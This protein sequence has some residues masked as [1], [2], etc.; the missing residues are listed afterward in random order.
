MDTPA[1]PAPKKVHANFGFFPQRSFYMNSFPE[2]ETAHRA[3]SFRKKKHIR[4]TLTGKEHFHQ[5]DF[6]NDKEKALT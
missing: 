3:S 5:C 2:P 6:M 1:T 4:F